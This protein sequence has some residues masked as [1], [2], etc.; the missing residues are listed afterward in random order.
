VDDKSYEEKIIYEK[1]MKMNNAPTENIVTVADTSEQVIENRL[2]NELSRYV[3]SM[4]QLRENT[5]YRPVISN[6]R[7]LGRMVVFVKRVIRKLV[8][9]YVEPVCNQQSAFNR[10]VTPSIGCLTEI[11]HGLE[12]KTMTMSR[13]QDELRAAQNEFHSIQN[14]MQE[15]MQEQMQ[16]QMQAQRE[17]NIKS[18]EKINE[19]LIEQINKQIHESENKQ[20]NRQMHDY[21]AMQQYVVQ[22]EGQLQITN[23]QIQIINN[24]MLELERLDLNIFTPDPKMDASYAE[25]Q[26]AGVY[27]QSGEDMIVHFLLQALGLTPNQITYLDLGANRAKQLS[28]T[29]HFYKRGARGVLVEANPALIP[30]LKFFRHGDIILNLCIAPEKSDPV[31]FYILSG[32][33]LSTSSKDSAEEI[34]TTN[35]NLKIEQVVS[36]ETI[37]INHLI[38]MYMGHAP[39][40]LNIDIEGSETDILYSLDFDRYRPL[41]IIIEV[42]PYTFPYTITKKNPEILDFMSKNEYCE[43]A[44]TGIN[45]IFA[46]IRHLKKMGRY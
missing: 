32:D 41:I 6:R 30:E 16:A 22:L 31:N 24:K 38:D 3:H 36:V 27:S 46:D 44:F 43:Y 25:V 33:G 1:L 23:E 40:L 7:I 21:E 14:K 28:N 17:E 19:Q 15:Q 35:P 20:T 5:S 2:F 39:T 4:E 11:S 18:H 29:F 26:R 8:S 34:I 37:T 10:A 13:Q 9:W 45:S 42:I 12:M